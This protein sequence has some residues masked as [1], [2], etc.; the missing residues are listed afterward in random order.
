LIRD[1]GLIDR[2]LS[3]LT[4]QVSVREDKANRLQPEASQALAPSSWQGG[5]HANRVRGTPTS[6]PGAAPLVRASLTPAASMSKLPVQSPPE[7]IANTEAPILGESAPFHQ[8]ANEVRKANKSDFVAKRAELKRT[9]RDFDKHYDHYRRW[10]DSNENDPNIKKI[11]AAGIIAQALILKASNA[12]DSNGRCKLLDLLADR[13]DLQKYVSPINGDFRAPTIGVVAGLRHADK[14]GVAVPTLAFPGT[15]A[16]AMIRSQLRINFQQVLRGDRPPAAYGLAVDLAQTIKGKL[17]TAVNGTANFTLTGHSLGGGMASFVG[18]S[19]ARPKENFVPN[20]YLYNPAALG[21][22]SIKHLNKQFPDDLADRTAKHVVIRVKYDQVSSPK[23]QHR[24][25]AVVNF[26]K[27]GTI[28]VPRHLGKVYVIARDL[29]KKSHQSLATL[30]RLE[31]FK[32]VYDSVNPP[33]RVNTS[34]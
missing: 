28:A 13:P 4:P 9:M 25:A 15:G 22:G 1:T 23:M 34:K 32:D 31:S 21:G 24:L 7:N 20:C 27:R 16:G 6:T 30:H 5:L 14:D 19:I 10:R 8:I 12:L 26:F 29:L 18:A 2:S 17:S 11:Q 33:P 3:G